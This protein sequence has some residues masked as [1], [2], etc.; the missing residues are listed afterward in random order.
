MGLEG[1]GGG[2]VLEGVLLLCFVVGGVVTAGLGGVLVRLLRLAEVA[3][4][5]GNMGGGDTDLLMALRGLMTGIAVA[6]VAP[7]LVGSLTLRSPANSSRL[8]VEVSLSSLPWWWLVMIAAVE[9]GWRAL[10]MVGV[11]KMLSIKLSVKP[12][13]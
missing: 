11:L 7:S 3:T 13:F 10:R 5:G 4:V 1:G 2:G 9:S 12:L 6:A 8:P